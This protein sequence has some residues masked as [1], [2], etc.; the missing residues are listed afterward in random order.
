VVVGLAVRHQTDQVVAA[1]V[2]DTPKDF[3]LI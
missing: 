1:A 2:E 3:L